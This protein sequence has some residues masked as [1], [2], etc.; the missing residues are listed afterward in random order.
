MNAA[1]RMAQGL[2]P[3]DGK[4][5]APYRLC[6]DCRRVAFVRRVANRLAE[7]GLAHK[8]KQG[9][10]NYYQTS[11]LPLGEGEVIYREAVEGDRRLLPRRAHV[12][13]DIEQTLIALFSKP[14]IETL[15][16]DEIVQAWGKL[17]VRPGRLSAAHDL[18]T[19]I[20]AERR[21][22]TRKRH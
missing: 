12:P 1:E 9:R 16:E 11:P 18:A 21:R 7:Y 22:R 8:T 5:A 4:E 6:S 2:C 20:L 3:N 15:T 17:R 10:S 14:G 13:I 19:I